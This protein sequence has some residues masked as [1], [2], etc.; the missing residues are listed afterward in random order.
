MLLILFLACTYDMESW[1]SP[2]A[3]TFEGTPDA[4]EGERIF[5]E[6]QWE[7]DSIYALTCAKCH[8]ASEGDTLFVD[9]DVLNRPGHTV[10]NAGL[11][12]SWKNKERWNMA[13]SD[14]LGAF[15]GQICVDV[16]FPGASKMTAEQAAHLEAWL[17]TRTDADPG[18][19]PRAK[20][21]G[22]DYAIWHNQ[23]D[24]LASIDG[25]FGEELG[26]V[27]E[28]EALTQTYCGSCHRTGEAGELV[29]LSAAV[30]TP[31]QI[32]Q[33]IRRVYIDGVKAPNSRMPRLPDDRLVDA[34]LKLILAYLSSGR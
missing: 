13:E 22:T 27:E 16:Y 19:D 4:V 14:T 21:L 26:A 15:G 3:S 23:S 34:D 18:D 12:G 20:P 2:L 8:N 31:T 17:K 7:D 5:N 33:R 25:K 9:D 10:Y 28:G 32:A 11:R 29:I 30:L 1:Q 6:E 24:F